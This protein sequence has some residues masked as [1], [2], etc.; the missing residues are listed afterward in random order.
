MILSALVSAVAIFSIREYLR[1]VFRSDNHTVPWMI[2]GVSYLTC[3]FL[4]TAAAFASWPAMILVLILNLIF[5]S[6]F[7]LFRFPAGNYLFDTIAR[8]AL[9]IMYIPLSLS[10]LLF[11]R[12]MEHGALWVFW[13][14]IVCFM[15]DTGAFYTGTFLENANWHPGSAPKKLWKDQPAVWGHP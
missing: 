6:A 1:I 15:N 11:V 12:N 10:L 2:S 8:Q 7:V 9:G 4:V 14:L 13:L 5:L 3:I